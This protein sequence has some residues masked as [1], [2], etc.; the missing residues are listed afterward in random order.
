MLL[1]VYPEEFFIG[2]STYVKAGSKFMPQE[3]ISGGGGGQYEV[4]VKILLDFK[5]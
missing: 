3:R 4:G 1:A 5:S 2:N